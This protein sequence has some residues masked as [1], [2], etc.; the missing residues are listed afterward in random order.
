VF[1]LQPRGILCGAVG[2]VIAFSLPACAQSSFYA[3]EFHHFTANAGAGYTSVAGRQ[4]NDLTNGWNFQAA[5]G[6]NFNQYF[7][8]LGTFMFNGLGV[9]NSALS[10]VNVPGGNARV[11]TLTVDPKLTFPIGRGSFYLLAGGGWLRRTVQFTQPVLATTFVFDPWW[12]Y[13]GPAVVPASQVL[14]SVSDN[15]GVWDVGGGFNI[16]LP[17]T[18]A[19][20]YVEARYIDGLTADTHTQIVPLTFGFRW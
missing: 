6:F 4:A 9:T 7:G 17:R 14:G 18:R 16:P 20:F 19:K 12:G 1:H 8:V 2:A 13:F 5:A 10:A 3:P 15:A 11:Y